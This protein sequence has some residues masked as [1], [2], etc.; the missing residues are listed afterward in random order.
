[1]HFRSLALPLFSLALLAKGPDVQI[2]ERSLNLQLPSASGMTATRDG[3][4]VVGD[5][6]PFLFKLD[7]H[8][9]I[10]DKSLLKDYPI[11]PD[12]RIP[13]AIKPDFEA[14]TDFCHKGRSFRLILGSGSKSVRQLALMVS[15]DGTQR[16]EKNMA[17]FYTQLATAAGF[18]S[19]TLVNL[20]GLAYSGGHFI[21]MNRVNSVSNV[22]FKVRKNELINFM[23]GAKPTVE[24]IQAFHVTLPKLQGNEAGLS[25]ADFMLEEGLLF[26]TS[27][28]E[29]TNDPINDGAIL[30]SYIGCIELDELKDG[31]D[32][33]PFMTL[34]TQAG[35]PVIT[36]IESIC[37]LP[38]QHDDNE[39]EVAVASD[40]D[41]GTSEF[42]RLKLRR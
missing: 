38:C 26:F 18:P 2:M 25:G 9:S 34:V 3:F 24:G 14:M 29:V 5:D 41:N 21:L 16:I 10:V 36:K 40:M 39:M 20:E 7:R 6:S 28:V 27:S 33:T 8:F 23:T 15:Q 32:L 22:I 1:M 35:S 12:G 31:M 13:K 19:G 30:G 37:L 42:F 4:F 11:G 17:P